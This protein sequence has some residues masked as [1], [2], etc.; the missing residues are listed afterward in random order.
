M[1]LIYHGRAPR[2]VC[3]RNERPANTI[4]GP[5]LRALQNTVSRVERK[6]EQ[7]RDTEVV[8]ACQYGSTYWP[9]K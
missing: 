7:G 2:I 1:N 8:L 6:R 4:R 5:S 9:G 3:R